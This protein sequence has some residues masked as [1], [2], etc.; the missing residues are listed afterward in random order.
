MGRR[1]VRT[2]APHGRRVY[3]SG[4]AGPL[5]AAANA[6]IRL[7]Y[8]AAVLARPS[9]PIGGIALSPNTEQFREA[10]LF[11]RGFA[12]HQLAVGTLGLVSLARP[13][14][15]R[16]AMALAAATDLADIVSAIVEASGRENDGPDVVGGTLF[17][18]A[19]LGSA[20]LALRG[21]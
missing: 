2:V 1:L 16:L 13:R 8:G 10:R 11:V 20:L 19:G 14:H 21:S 4:I 5:F 18:A 3:G 12:A 17:S 9:E 15:R 6:A 7:G